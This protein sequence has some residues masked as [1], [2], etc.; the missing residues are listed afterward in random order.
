MK[1][2][3]ITGGAG[4]IGAHCA[5]RFCELGWDV[6]V[7]D[8][9]SRKGS[10]ANLSWLMETCGGGVSFHRQ[11]IRND[12]AV[13][14]LFRS[15]GRVELVLHLAAQTA[16]TLS[17]QDPRTDFDVNALGTFNMLEAVRVQCPEAAFIYASTNKVYGEMGH[18]A[19]T[20]RGGRYC[21]A[22][23]PFGASEETPLDF[24]S[25]YGCSKGTGDQ[26]TVDYARIYGIRTVSMR[27]SC[28][29]GTR[30]FGIEDQGWVAWFVIAAVLGRP[31]TIYGDGKQIRDI[32]YVDDLVDCYIRAFERIDTVKG[33]AYNIGGGPSRTMSILELVA[34]LEAEL[35]LKLEPAFAPW[36]PG[37]QKVFV[38]DV[39]RAKADLGWAPAVTNEDG[40][41]RLVSWVR[42]NKTLLE[43]VL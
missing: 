17:V 43:S 19:V 21:Y 2:I 37:D 12:R 42:A 35:G 1:K 30:Q 39:S 6:A 15:L 5:A 14:D 29:Y 38:A 41:R 31:L 16:V 32:L 27:Q 13:S 22:D 40:V 34:F 9:L 20:E 7:L 10:E 11:D 23:L 25:P 28:I 3:L 26:Y 4:F 33:A 24:H 18:A 8:N 36:R